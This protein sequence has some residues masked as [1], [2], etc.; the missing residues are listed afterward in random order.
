TLT[1]REP[2]FVWELKQSALRCKLIN[3][4]RKAKGLSPLGGAFHR[5]RSSGDKANDGGSGGREARDG[6]AAAS[7]DDDDA[8]LAA[9]SLN[10]PVAEAPAPQDRAS[11]RKPKRIIE[12]DEDDDDEDDDDSNNNA[13]DD[14]CNSND[15]NNKPEDAD[16]LRNVGSDIALDGDPGKVESTESQTAMAVVAEEE[17]VAK[18]SPVRMEATPATASDGD[19]SSPKRK[20]RSVLDNDQLA[21]IIFNDE[22]GANAVA[23][24][25]K[26]LQNGLER[27]TEAE[28]AVAAEQSAEAEMEQEFIVDESA[29]SMF[30]AALLA[31]TADASVS[32]LEALGVALGA[33]VLRRSLEWDRSGMIAEL[34]EVVDK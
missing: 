30:E 15:S 1:K 28:P 32:E 14:N 22:I 17:E 7:A 27:E 3:E 19:A 34:V 5:A 21:A 16:G 11:P 12:D 18:E 10:L 13:G 9:Y 4:Q 8:D 26:A 2:E 23:D 6:D 20:R 33:V 24:S 31:K 29:L 25:S